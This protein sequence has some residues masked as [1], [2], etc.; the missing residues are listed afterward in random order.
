MKYEQLARE[1]SRALHE[2][3]NTPVS[4]QEALAQARQLSQRLGMSPSIRSGEIVINERD[5]GQLEFSD[6]QTLFPESEMEAQLARRGL[7]LDQWTS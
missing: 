5:D 6:E 1:V 4:W 7:P 3:A 2:R